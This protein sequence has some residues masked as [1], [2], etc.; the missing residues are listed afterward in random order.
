MSNPI[1][2]ELSESVARLIKANKYLTDTMRFKNI[3]KI[4]IGI[5]AVKTSMQLFQTA[6]KNSPESLGGAIASAYGVSL[7]CE[8][9][10]LCEEAVKMLRVSFKILP[11]GKDAIH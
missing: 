1:N 2:S 9:E 10:R 8:S 6:S 5:E 7:L 4:R 11:G 3:G